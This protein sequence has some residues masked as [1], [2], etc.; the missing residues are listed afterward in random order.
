MRNLF[1][2]DSPLMR[3][4]ER[5]ADLIALNLVW[6][7]C[8]LG[9]VTIGPATIAKC[10]IA[11]S[12]ARGDSPPVLRRFF[13]IFRESF[14]FGLKLFCCLLVPTALA[15]VY[16]LL[17]ASGGLDGNLLLKYLCYIGVAVIAVV[18][19]FAY[20]LAAHFENSL[21][22]TLRNAVLL[23]LGNPVLALLT[24]VLNLLPLILALYATAFFSRIW[25]F[26]LV[27]GFSGTALVNAW[28]LGRF[29]GRLGGS[30]EKAESP[31]RRL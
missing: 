3:I 25:I 29:F 22:Q 1:N 31:R 27:I 15:G 8:C 28:L 30:G 24:A 16:L 17:A 10:S 12:M 19:T 5:V 13:E 23:P 9:F 14:V 7:G 18:C 21:G 2:L 11:R 26:W 20:P 4:L 6:L